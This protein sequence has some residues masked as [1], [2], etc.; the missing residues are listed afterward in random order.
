M[1]DARQKRSRRTKEQMDELLAAVQGVLDNYDGD[2][3]SVRQLC[4]RL[5]S[6]GVIAKTE[7]ELS[8]EL[9]F[10]EYGIRRLKQDIGPPKATPERLTRA[11]QNVELGDRRTTTQPV[12]QLA[13]LGKH[14][15]F[16]LPRAIN[17]DFNDLR[18][19]QL[20]TLALSSDRDLA[21]I[22]RADPARSFPHPC[23]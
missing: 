20:V 1:H 6:V 4:Y 18:W 7:R 23:S 8:G 21:D 9:S 14:N 2:R 16:H 17:A 13:P 19:R 10:G 3:I 22:A 15:R 12:A 5:A 11:K